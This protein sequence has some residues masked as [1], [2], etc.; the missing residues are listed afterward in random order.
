M[1]NTQLS[2]SKSPL[3]FDDG[4]EAILDAI[5][6]PIIV[7]D[8]QSQ[9]RFLNDAACAL[10]GRGRDDLIGLTDFDVLPASEADRIREMDRRVL[11]TGEE[12]LFEQEITSAD[13]SVR[14]LLTQKRRA[15]L[16]SGHS[17]QQLVVA[18]ILDVT[19]RRRAESELRASEEHY[20]S[21]VELHPQV[22]WTADPSGDVL[23]VGPR[24]KEIT[25]FEPADAFGTGWA[26]AMQP[27]DLETVERQWSKSVATGN[28]LDVEFRLAD[29]Q[30]GYH[31][32]R[33]RAAARRAEDGTVTRWYGLVENID[34]RRKALEALKESEARFRAIADDAPVMIWVADENG[35]SVYQ[36]RVW[37][38]TTGQ[39]AEQAQG[40]GWLDAIHPD[41]RIDA[42]AAFN[43]AL[44][45]RTPVRTEYRLR[46]V[47]GSYAWVID[48][49]QPRF[50]TDGGF[51]GYVG[52]GLDIT[53]RRQAELALVESEALIR[54]VFESTPDCIRLLDLDGRPLLMNRAGRQLF[55]LGES[56]RL[57]DVR[58]EKMVP[59]SDV[60]KAE[61]V[62]SEV[63][64][65]RTTRV[66]TAIRDN[67]G[68][69][70]YMDV[71]TAPVLGAFGEPIRMLAIWRDI[72]EARK[73][74]DDAE[75][76]RLH[77]ERLAER[78][79]GVLESTMDSVVVADRD[80]RIE[81]LNSK[82]MRL[83]QVD[84]QA[85]GL[86]LWRLFP[87]N[88]SSVFAVEYRKVMS[89]HSST[90]FEAYLEGLER[91]LEVH[92]APT[93]E[94]ISLFFRDITERHK[95]EQERLLAHRQIHHM[96][97]HD[98]VTGLPNR[99]F[100]R[101]AFER[102]F[103]GTRA[104]SKTAVLSLDLD[105]FKAVNDA[106]G[107]PTGDLLL[108][109]VAER[110]RRC[111]EGGD[112]VA[113]LGGDEFVILRTGVRQEEEAID[114]S[115]R[116]IDALGAPYELDGVQADIGVR[117]GIAFSPR[118]GRAADQLIKA[119]DIA[120]YR[121]KARGRGTYIQFE[122]GMDAHLQARQQM[123]V[124]LRR[125]LANDELELHYQPLVN[126]RTGLIATCEAL[127]RWN[128]PEK[129]AISPVDFIPLAEETGLIVPLGEWILRRAC[130]EAVQWPQ[131]VSVAVNLSPLQFRSR[132]LVSVVRDT[133]K[134][135][136][137]DASRLQIEVTES[138][139]LDESDNNLRVLQDIRRLGV[140]IA[141]DDFG[142]GYSSLGYLRTF[143]FDKIKVDRGFISDLPTGKESLAII[144]AVAG[145]GRTL[146]ITTAVEGVETQTQLDVIHAEGFDEAQGYLFARP[147]TAARV[148]E[149]IQVSLLC[150]VDFVNSH[151]TDPR[152]RSVKARVSFP[153]GNAGR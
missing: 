90:T 20:R 115:Q 64:Q 32:F 58:W 124:E 80:W 38:E 74:R 37:L 46:R 152:S 62:Y 24:W 125:A 3:R 83:L 23:E 69:E 75:A 110:L 142:T 48:V 105:G 79:S 14:N 66:E 56:T 96:A 116:I 144:R 119:A 131:Q 50:A 47:D 134:E 148:L 68:A 33:S 97:R 77:A 145:I 35:A 94:G 4:L 132:R 118:D 101:E 149:A 36:S 86:D 19:A 98:A 104:R 31:W 85:V 135:S 40:F 138:V 107:H 146:G 8:E 111:V 112:T 106:Y 12:F 55:G 143:A 49:G 2:L 87:V 45:L 72:T 127:V 81:Y 73:A 10:I 22:P 11:S 43:E 91:W 34:D 15:E 117:V 151:T 84:E 99:Q 76:A 42:E 102:L 129:G 136:G 153:K 28:P 123:K 114:L 5:P 41:D 60:A 63:R 89:E 78:L 92:A 126:L 1:E 122:P 103:E 82:A 59:A 113:R 6:Q 17:K 13:G 44:R 26:K 65:G 139:L 54:S 128:H 141:M 27:D 21:L 25:G 130:A 109:S 67:T 30:G 52:V 61:A 39:I 133:L 57:E 137:L 121:A 53:E 7:K 108:R 29:G 100:L 120:L 140:K 95:A 150:R 88:D 51:L 147:L 71:I 18:T 70:R 93:F 16:T 9:F